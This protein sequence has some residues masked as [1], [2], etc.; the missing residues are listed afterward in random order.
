MIHSGPASRVGQ[1]GGSAYARRLSVVTGV[2]VQPDPR[3]PARHDWRAKGRI[4]ACGALFLALFAGS[5]SAQTVP[6]FN[7]NLD[8]TEINRRG[9][10]AAAKTYFIPTVYLRIT[11]RTQTSINNEGASAKAKIYVDGLDK[12]TFQGLAKKVYDDLVTKIRAAGYTVLTYD[13]LK[14]EMTAMPRMKLNEKFGFPTK[15]FDGGT[16]IDFAIVAPSDE[17]AF[18]YG[19]TGLTFG[20]RDIARTK[21]VVVLVPDIY[22]TLTEVAGKKG[23]SIWG[24]SVELSILPPMRLHWGM[25]YALPPSMAGGDIRIKEHGMRLAADVAGSV[26]KV[27]ENNL[28]YA[29]W[30]RTTGDFIFTLDPVAVSNGVLRVG[31]AINDLTVSTIRK[32]HE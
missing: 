27:S 4:T 6:P 22:F 28:D 7:I 11:A 29:G 1:E 14:G 15:W 24:K 30:S 32:A 2:H 18:D 19:V 9:D 16:G 31:Y 5:A 23:S 12:A 17:Q 3:F 21:N 20:Y 8:R 25:V 26:K 10:F 13:D